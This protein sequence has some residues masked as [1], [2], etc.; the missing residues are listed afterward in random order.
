LSSIL[1]KELKYFSIAKD[2]DDIIAIK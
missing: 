1:K 2:V